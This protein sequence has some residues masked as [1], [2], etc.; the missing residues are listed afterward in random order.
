MRLTNPEDIM[1]CTKD[2]IY[3]YLRIGHREFWQWI[4]DNAEASLKQAPFILKTQWPGWPQYA[5]VISPSFISE[6]SYC[7]ACIYTGILLKKGLVE[8]GQECKN[9]PIKWEEG[10]RQDV[11][12]LEGDGLYTRWK[13]ST[14][15]EDRR[16]Y[17]I[18]IKEG[19]A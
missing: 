12:C 18:L 1:L 9:C 6:H 17:A 2:E 5:K 16:K 7:F 13:K 15:V 14:T 4:A 8:N 3:Y 10:E 19:W 11:E